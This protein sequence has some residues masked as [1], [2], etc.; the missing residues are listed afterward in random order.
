[1]RRNFT[2]GWGLAAFSF[3]MGCAAPQFET[4]TIHDSPDQFVK[5]F[6]VPAG[7]SGKA[8]SH[9]ISISNE[10]MEEV[11][12]GVMIQEFHG[13]IPL[14]FMNKMMKSKRHRAFS[15]AWVSFFAPKLIKG[16]QQATPEEVVVF[17]ETGKVTSLR[18]MTTSGGI[19]VHEEALHIFLSNYH[20]LTDTGQDNEEYTAS[21]R[22]TPLRPI[23]PEPGQLEFEP[24]TYMVER[25]DDDH[26]A[27][28]GKQILQVGVL[29]E[30]LPVESHAETSTPS[31]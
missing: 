15:D 20:V 12:K 23:H 11:L 26:V 2:T 6:H 3:L 25:G 28:L 18:Q 9:P 29:Y 19:F 17:F 13:S 16:L 30:K 7:D 14:P 24:E 22:L 1:M 27:F 8:F 5:L 31:P 4:V 21:F 10:K